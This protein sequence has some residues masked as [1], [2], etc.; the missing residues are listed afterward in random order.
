MP[1]T[2]EGLKACK[3]LASKGIKL[4]LLYV[5]VLAK[6]LLAAESR[7]TYV[8]PF[9]GRLDDIGEEGIRLIAEI[10]RIVCSAQSRNQNTHCKA[11]EILD[12]LTDAIIA[13]AD[14]LTI[15]YKVLLQLYKH[16]LTDR[17]L[18]Q[19]IEDWEKSG[20]KT[21]LNVKNI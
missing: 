18:S 17:G 3:A 21:S 6:A 2:Q 4:M 14:L 19:F 9:I 7:T 16:P 8:S 12:I 1:L 15:P 5:S 11:L 10:K 20:Q 13:G